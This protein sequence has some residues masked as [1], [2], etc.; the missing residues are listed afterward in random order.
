MSNEALSNL[1]EPT[2]VAN[3]LG[4]SPG[5]LSVWRCSGRQ[6]LP[7]VKVGR[8][9][10]YKPEDVQNFIERRTLAHTA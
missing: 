1:L 8:K 7:F 3:I 5:T 2:S 10:M 9:V 4:V 6:N